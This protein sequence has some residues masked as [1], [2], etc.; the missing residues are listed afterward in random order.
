MWIREGYEP[1]DTPAAPRERGL[2]LACF[3]RPK[4]ETLR[5]TLEEYNGHDFVRAERASSSC[6]S[7]GFPS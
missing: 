6:R 5:V 4:G 3:E 1:T 2:R 7:P